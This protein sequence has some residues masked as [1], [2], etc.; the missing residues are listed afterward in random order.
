MATVEH[1]GNPRPTLEVT[2][3]FRRH[4]K[5]CLAAVIVGLYLLSI[6]PCWYP[7]PD[8][9]VYLML[10]KNLAQGEGYVL[11]GHPH[12]QFPPGFPAL[13]ALMTWWGLGSV[14][15]LNT[16]MVLMALATLWL[17]YQALLELCPKRLALVVTLV[18]ASSHVFHLASVRLLS[19][20][21][22]MLL[23]WVAMVCYLRG[24]RREG[25]W[26]ELGT[27]ALLVGCWFRV[28]GVVLAGAAAVGLLLQPRWIP[29]R[30]VWLNAAVLLAGAALTLAGFHAYCQATVVVE[31]GALPNYGDSVA[32]MGARSSWQWLVK[33]LGNIYLTSRGLAQVLTG[34]SHEDVGWPMVLCWLPVIWGMGMSLRRRQWLGVMIVLGYCGSVVLLCPLIPRYMLPVAPLLFLYF[35]EGM[36]WPLEWFCRS[37]RYAPAVALFWAAVLLVVNVPKMAQFVYEVHQPG[38]ATSQTREQP[39]ART[40]RFLRDRA[41]PGERFVGSYNDDQL[42]Y[43]SEVPTLPMARKGKRS[44]PYQP[45]DFQRWLEEGVRFAVLV[46]GHAPPFLAPVMTPDFLR[47]QGFRPIR[48]F[49]EYTVYRLADSPDG[50]G[51]FGEN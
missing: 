51:P 45:A 9:A 24:L 38:F 25:Y 35:C 13:V 10:G 4:L 18:L 28:A 3:E 47:A 43:L 19:D 49:G 2:W 16:A 11:W 48:Q 20:L 15:C 6:S 31:P 22:Y 39:L 21:P 34:Q 40:A 1:L 12:V 50:A 41:A 37:R 14:A 33:P 27:A 23:V 44:N 5:W 32:A 26:L 8:S 7:T 42:A 30:R 46:E 29:A 36:S 17:C